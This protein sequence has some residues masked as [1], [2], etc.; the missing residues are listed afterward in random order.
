MRKQ[1]GFDLMICMVIL[2]VFGATAHAEP[3]LYSIQ[4]LREVTSPVWQQTY[5]AYGRTIEVNKEVYVP[6]VDAAPVIMVSLMPP[7]PDVQRNELAA[8]YANAAKTDLSRVYDFRSD[9]FN[10]VICHAI[11]PEWGERSDSKFIYGEMSWGAH[12][13]FDYDMDAAYAEDNTLTVAEA[14]DIA[15]KT[16]EGVL[17]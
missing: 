7:L 14:F 17:P 4:E 5:Q 3:Q 8:W 16:A 15:Q 6:Q 11:Y 1:A 12:G 2:L 13:V 10:T 9:D